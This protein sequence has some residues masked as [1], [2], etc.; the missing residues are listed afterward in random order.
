MKF[1]YRPF[2]RYIFALSLG[3]LFA[4]WFMPTEAGAVGV[5][6]VFLVMAIKGRMNLHI[7]KSSLIDATRTTAMIMLLVTYLPSLF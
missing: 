3:G 7:I 4:G 5:A 1:I 6:G 2:G